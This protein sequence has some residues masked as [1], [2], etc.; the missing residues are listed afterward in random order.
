MKIGV[1]LLTL[2]TTTALITG[3]G[4]SHVGYSSSG[5]YDGPP[6][7]TAS[8]PSGRSRLP[9][10]Q[11]GVRKT[12][13]P[14]RIAG[15]WYYPLATA[16]GYNATGTA[17]WYG[18]K[19]HGRK[20][21]NGERYDMHAM[22]AAHKTLPMPTMVRVTNLNNGRSVV[23]RVNDRG[24]FV[25]NR[26]ID[27]SYAAARAL[28]Y[29]NEGTAPVRVEALGNS[30]TASAGRTA[31]GSI[32]KPPI[33]RPTPSVTAAQQPIRR[34]IPVTRTIRPGSMYIQLGAFSSTVNANRLKAELS[35]NY[36]SVGIYAKN[37]GYAEVYR[38]RIG[39][40]EDEKEIERQVL[41]LQRQ[42]Y[43]NAIVVIE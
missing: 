5:G 36:P 33:V 20:T 40:F 2:L 41:A 37:G 22:S 6:A 7:S 31:P 18:T 27:L 34:H 38:V 29:D 4:K 8:Y 14:Y 10:G 15:K 11:G 43:T 3:C 25:K 23:V 13:K 9:S 1:W 28:G 24:P 35:G 42:G 21:A 30:M 39:P 16:N 32:T 12:G 19:F 26:I 17:S